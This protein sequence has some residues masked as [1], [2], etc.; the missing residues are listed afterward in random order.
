MKVLCQKG[1]KMGPK[2]GFSGIIKVNAWNFMFFCMKLKQHKNLQLTKLIFWETL[3]FEVFGPKGAQNGPKMRFVKFCDKSMHT[4]SLI[5]SM[6]LKQNKG[7]R[8]TQVIFRKNLTPEFL[9]KKR[10]KMIF[11][12][13][14]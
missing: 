8:L 5:F 9:D 11:F 4:N 14:N 7:L 6:K 3:S 1:P 12:T 13:T 10:P 2:K